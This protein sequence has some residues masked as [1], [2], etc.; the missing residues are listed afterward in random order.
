MKLSES[1]IIH[2]FR[3]VALLATLIFVPGIA[4][5]WNHL[6]KAHVNKSSPKPVAIKTEESQFIRKDSSESAVFI[7]ALP[8]ESISPSLPEPIIEPTF[9]PPAPRV[10]SEVSIQQVSWERSQQ[11]PPQN[12]EL[13]EQYLKTLGA[14]YY[15]LEKW[16]NRGELFRFSCFVTPLEP[17]SYEKHF[18][19]IGADAVTVMRSVIAEI[20]AWKSV[21]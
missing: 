4:I 1:P 3:G 10:A 17:H 16:G 21:K 20:E 7:S 5:F 18:Q 2:F 8:P 12:F 15:R 9:S 14:T 6:P 19:A 11:Q 13:L